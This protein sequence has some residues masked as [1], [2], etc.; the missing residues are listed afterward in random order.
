MLQSVSFFLSN[1]MY[2]YYYKNRFSRLW[3][4]RR[5]Y[6]CLLDFTLW[7]AS[8]SIISPKAEVQ[9]QCQLNVR[10]RWLN[11]ALGN[12]MVGFLKEA[13]F[14]NFLP[15]NSLIIYFT[16]ILE[17]DLPNQQLLTLFW[18]SVKRFQFLNLEH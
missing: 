18:P 10:K 6:Y 4:S 8:I 5:F 9:R 7:W 12:Y 3:F 16:N 13:T 2:T 14:S 17:I 11:F 1:S 15:E